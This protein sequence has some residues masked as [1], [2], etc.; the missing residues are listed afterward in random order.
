MTSRR[1]GEAWLARHVRALHRL[2]VGSSESNLRHCGPNTPSGTVH[3][4]VCRFDHQER[5]AAQADRIE[6][7]PTE[8]GRAANMLDAYYHIHASDTFE[9][10]AKGRLPP[11]R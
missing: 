3:S 1:A 2:C 9:V 5:L 6:E 4:E 11:A 10:D 8:R 7:D